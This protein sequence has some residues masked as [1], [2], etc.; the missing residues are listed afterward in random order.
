MTRSSA[1]AERPRDA[2]GH[3]IFCLFTQDHSRSVEIASFDRSHTS[4][5]WLSIVG[6]SRIVSEIKRDIGRKSR[7]FHTPLCNRRPVRR[8]LVGIASYGNVCYG[9]HCLKNAPTLASCSF[10]KHGLIVIIFGKH[11]G[12]VSK[13]MCV[14]NFPCLFTFTYFICVQMAAMERTRNNAFSSVDCW[15]L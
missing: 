2:S 7:F 15:W 12:T 3:L 14:F 8:V 13:M 9:K 6:L 4:S 1:V 5:Y 11:I 10:D